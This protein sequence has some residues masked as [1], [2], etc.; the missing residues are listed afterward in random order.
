MSI[1]LPQNR[2]PGSRGLGTIGTGANDGDHVV[3]VIERGPGSLPRVFAVLAFR[4]ADMRCGGALT[5]ARRGGR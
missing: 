5:T 4:T 1:F 3:Q 2:Q